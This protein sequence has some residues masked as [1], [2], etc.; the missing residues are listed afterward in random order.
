[1]NENLPKRDAV[2]QFL[3]TRF[4]P[5]DDPRARQGI[6]LQTTRVLRRRRRMKQ[7]SFLAALA[8]CYA[9]G[10]GTMRLWMT[11]PASPTPATVVE[12]TAEQTPEAPVPAPRPG[13]LPLEKDPDVPAVVIERVAFASDEQRARLLFLR[14]GNRYLENDGDM[15][16]ALRCYTQA[17]ASAKDEDLTISAEDNWFLMALKKARLEEKNH[18]KNGG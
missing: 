8:A 11:A 16:A 7:L 14:A 17:L 15:E 13:A 12:R 5:A 2:E 4:S 18:A 3:E 1:M 10:L 9:A 6:L